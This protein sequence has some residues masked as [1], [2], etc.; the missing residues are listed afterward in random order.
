MTR[1]ERLPKYVS[2]F[3]DNR[4]KRRYRFRKGG[5]SRYIDGHPNSPA[6]K[7]EYAALLAGETEKSADKRKT[8][9]GSVDDLLTRYY[10]STDFRGKA[11]E[12]S[13]AK[14]RAVLEA[15]RAKHG[16]RMVRDARYDKL[17]K[18][19]AEIAVGWEDENGRKHGGP[20]AAETAR[21]LIRGLFKY[22]V[23]LEWR[24]DNPMDHIDYRPKK[25]SGFH[26]WTEEEVEQYQA[27]WPL[28]TK[29]RLAM[30]LCLWTGK[31]RGDAIRLGPQHIRGDSLWGRDQKT[32][33]DWELPISRQLR[34][35]IDAMPE[36]EHLCFVP[37]DRGRPYSAA[38]F[39]NMFRQWCDKA[40]LPH[41]S[42]HGLRKAISRRLAE[43]EVGNAGIKSVTLHS[44]DD[45]VS[46]YVA[47]ADQKRLARASID[48]ISERHLSSG[49]DNARQSS[50]GKDAK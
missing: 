45:E 38:S 35:A 36:A 40:G 9:P 3:V 27:H 41:C 20:F 18:Y 49:V 33:K 6:G 16:H 5:I 14:R 25:T 31:R 46:L 15:F 48:R 2:C 10:G 19:I 28:G 37:S 22:A 44:R 11:Q 4:G 7:V 1:K 30:E 43:A 8:I 13:L 21:K 39:G 47:A 29:Q 50:K 24:A 32:G 17:D 23:K 12:H 42:A 34:E 26:S